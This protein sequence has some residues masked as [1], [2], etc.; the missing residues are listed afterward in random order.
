MTKHVLPRISARMAD[1]ISSSVRMSTFEVASSRIS[2]CDLR[3]MARAMVSSCFCP[4]EMFTPS[5]V[6]TVS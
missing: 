3:S 5:S 1:W 6:S 2:R 4:L